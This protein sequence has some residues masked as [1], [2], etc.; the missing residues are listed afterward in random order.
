MVV[1]DPGAVSNSGAVTNPG[2]RRDPVALIYHL[3]Y[4]RP[5][6]V[7]HSGTMMNT[8]AMSPRFMR[9]PEAVRDSRL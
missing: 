3:V 1:I 6:A 5:W 7:K 9:K 2:S 4:E 8:G